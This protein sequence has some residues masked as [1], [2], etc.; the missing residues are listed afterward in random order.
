MRILAPAS[1]FMAALLVPTFASAAPTI[2]QRLVEIVNDAWNPLFLLVAV[3]AALGGIYLFARGLMKLVA[4]STERGQQASYS[5][6]L[7]YLAIAAM[8]IALPDAAGMGMTSLL[9]AARGNAD[10]GSSTLDY[11]DSG[12]SGS[13]MT[14]INGSL[15]S[16]GD[17][18]NCLTADS[19]ATCMAKNIATNVI[20]MA[21]Y[22]LFAMVFV[23]GLV[24][25]AMA[26][27]D[28]A[29]NSEGA[30]HQ[31]KPAFTKMITAVL[32]MNAPLA[33]GIAS[34][35]L[36]GSD[37]TIGEK[38]LAASSDLLKYTGG[39]KIAIITKYQEMIGH[40]FTILTFF[41]AW[42]FVR[43][44]FMIKSTAEGRH[45]GT[46]GMAAVYIIAGILMANAKMSTCFILS[47]VGGSDMA[48]GFCTVAG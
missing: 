23:L 36:F 44:V 6:G 45:Q 3:G 12:V 1:A 31:H 24:M 11:G 2:G 17:V 28:M 47:T 48:T 43:G 16:V 21:V 9:G 33:F 34:T 41:G 27:V 29:K 26:L 15:G 42:S 19:P 39:S 35:T 22:A 30:S 10:L 4:A 25:F 7:A 20:P 38:G 32:L 37:G 46:M 14:A 8:L 5:S 13:W 18:Q 40:S